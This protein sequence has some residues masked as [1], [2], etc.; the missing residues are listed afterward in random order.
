MTSNL[1]WAAI[2]IGGVAGGRTV[3]MRLLQ[4]RER[5][6]LAKL[7]HGDGNRQ[8]FRPRLFNKFSQNLYITNLNAGP[9]RNR[10]LFDVEAVC[11]L[12]K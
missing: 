7:T 3:F 4:P 10:N 5:N 9:K 2:I 12:L 1:G 6:I 11:K 8:T